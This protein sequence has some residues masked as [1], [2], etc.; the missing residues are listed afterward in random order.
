MEYKYCPRCGD[1]FQN[2]VET[3]PDCEVALGFE[4]PDRRAGSAVDLPAARHLQA[5]FVGEPWQVREPVDSLAAAAIPCRVDAFPPGEF[6][7]DG[8]GIGSFG[9]GTRVGVYVREQDIPAIVALGEEW[10]R[11]TLATDD[12]LDACPACGAALVADATGCGD[13]G[14]EFPEIAMCERCG[15]SMPLDAAVCGVCRAP[16][17]GGSS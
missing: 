5:I 9:A 2:W 10:V 13:C 12:E 11:S 6:S 16:T 14:L 15:A 8:V 7:D 4:K 1:E 3:C 17:G